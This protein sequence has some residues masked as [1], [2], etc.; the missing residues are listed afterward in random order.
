MDI[1]VRGW[2]RDQEKLPYQVSTESSIYCGH[3]RTTQADVPVEKTPTFTG[4]EDGGNDMVLVKWLQKAG[5]K[6]IVFQRRKKQRN[7]RK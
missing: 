5:I 2:D 4:W 1:W 6:Y 7:Q 3:L